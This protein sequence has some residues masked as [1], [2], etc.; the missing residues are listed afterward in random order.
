MSNSYSPFF[1]G[2]ILF[3]ILI[4]TPPAVDV[5]YRAHSPAP[6]LFVCDVLS[7]EHS[8]TSLR[9]HAPFGS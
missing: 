2:A 6:L 5:V 1:D 8:V 4:D 3:I 9:N 7:S